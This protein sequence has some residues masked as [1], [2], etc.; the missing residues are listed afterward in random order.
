MYETFL[1]SEEK[2]EKGEKTPTEVKLAHI[3]ESA[4]EA[5]DIIGGMAGKLSE[6]FEAAGND[7]AADAMDTVEGVM[8]TV[9]NIG[10][11]FAEGGL[12]GGIA[13]AAGEA[14]GWITKAFQANA[15]HKA[16]LK[17]IMTET[18]A[19]QREYNLALMEQNL[20]YE[21]ATTIFGTDEYG[22]AANAVTVLKDAVSDLNGELKGT[23][24][25]SGGYLSF[26]NGAF[27]KIDLLSKEQRKFYDAYAGLADF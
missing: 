9:S 25:Y 11:G 14:I 3:G 15:R 18:I 6:M 24:K 8:S 22:K 27:G 5:A 7:G 10:K 20:E 12:V 19:Q 17:K 21:K 26:F 4:A 2:N 13:A 16:A 23:G 1:F